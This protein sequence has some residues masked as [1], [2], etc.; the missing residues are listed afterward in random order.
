MRASP[1][2]V[3]SHSGAGPGATCWVSRP[4]L[5]FPHQWET[6]FPQR[7][8]LDPG[9]LLPGPDLSCCVSVVFEKLLTVC[10][11]SPGS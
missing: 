5:L 11:L 8:Q 10:S 2:G 6:N 4:E 1:A 9:P 3:F 7:L